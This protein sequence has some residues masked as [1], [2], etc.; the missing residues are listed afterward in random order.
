[1]PEE[2]PD[3]DHPVY[4]MPNHGRLF[5]EAVAE[6]VRD[7]A[8]QHPESVEALVGYWLIRDGKK[9][10][11][12][13]ARIWWCHHEPGCPDNKLD[14][15]FLAG[16]I[17]GQPVDPVD[18][19]AAHDHQEMVPK[20]GLTLAQEYAWRVADMEHARE[21]RPDDPIANPRRRINLTKIPPLEPPE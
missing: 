6:S 2:K 13:P 5:R 4:R 15:P 11:L 18:I 19:Y 7:Y 9:R 21:Y 3:R 10:P 17:A 14:Q 12:I 1:M 20:G 8:R 16:E